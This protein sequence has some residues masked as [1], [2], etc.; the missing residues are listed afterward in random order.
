M[1]RLRFLCT[2]EA[3][4]E[5]PR[6]GWCGKPLDWEVASLNGS[7]TLAYGKL[8]LSVPQLFL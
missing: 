6:R 2:F 7:A 1:A 3:R 5:E 8:S 4:I